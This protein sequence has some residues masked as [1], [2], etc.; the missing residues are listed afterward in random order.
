M[1][2]IEIII[3]KSCHFSPFNSL[4]LTRLSPKDSSIL[5]NLESPFFILGVSG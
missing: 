3:S 2:V 1:N 5:I 4:G